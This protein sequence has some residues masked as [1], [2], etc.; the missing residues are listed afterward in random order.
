MLDTFEGDQIKVAGAFTF[1]SGFQEGKSDQEVY[2]K[3]L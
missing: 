3:Q 2:E 1:G